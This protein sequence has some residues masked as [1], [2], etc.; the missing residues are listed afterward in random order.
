MGWSYE[1]VRPLIGPPR[2]ELECIPPWADLFDTELYD[3]PLVRLI[4]SII[5][6]DGI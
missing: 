3:E 6:H 1:G 5:G 2:P 4:Q